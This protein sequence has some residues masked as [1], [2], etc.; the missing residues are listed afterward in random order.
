MDF[1]AVR[2]RS[3]M[4]VVDDNVQVIVETGT[5]DDEPGDGDDFPEGQRPPRQ[6]FHIVKGSSE[7]VI[8]GNGKNEAEARRQ[9]FSRLSQKIDAV[10]RL[11][12]LTDAQSQKLELAGRGDVH[13][14]FEQ[15]TEMRSKI[16]AI[17][18]VDADDR[19]SLL[20]RVVALSQECRPLRTAFDAG[21]FAEGSLF[22]KALRR[23]LT[24]EQAARYAR[25]ESIEPPAK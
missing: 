15:A 9:L 3:L 8:F 24:P 7:Q 21:P 25:R 1:K 18:A 22:A 12:G 17:H 5:V 10:N 19:R 23:I 20:N 13:R 6:Q 2:A 16:E 4:V 11:C 14:L